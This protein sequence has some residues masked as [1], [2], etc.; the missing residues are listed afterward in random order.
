MESTSIHLIQSGIA[1][2]LALFPAKD[3]DPLV[4]AQYNRVLSDDYETI[5]DFLVLHYHATE[6]KP[7][8]LWEHCRHMALPDT[9][10]Y[11]EEHFRRTGRIVLGTDELFRDASWFAV[12]HGAGDRADRLQPADRRRPAPRTAAAHLAQRQGGRLPRPPAADAHPRAIHPRATAPRPPLG[13]GVTPPLPDP[14]FSLMAIADPRRPRSR[15]PPACSP[16]P[17]RPPRARPEYQVQEGL[18]QN[19]FVQDGTVAAHLLLRSGKTPRILVAFPAGNSGVGLWFAPQATGDELDDHA[20]ADAD[21]PAD[22]HG[23]PLYGMV[24]EAS[25]TTPS[26]VVGRA[27][28]LE[29]PCAARFRSARD[30]PA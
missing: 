8:P 24:T 3:C 9:L 28:A 25:A 13:V 15:S 20:A 5:R 19:A 18:N 26:L 6:G 22:R 23:R 4:A 29:R 14:G 21:Y 27:V 2:L 17:R 10:V 12:L 1:K 30:G 16:L 7:Q 11:R